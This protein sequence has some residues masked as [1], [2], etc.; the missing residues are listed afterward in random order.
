MA[1]NNVLDEITR[2][3]FMQEGKQQDF[4]RY[5]EKLS[6]HID[7][8]AQVSHLPRQQIEAIAY[9]T[10]RAYRL[11]WRT[12]WFWLA[13][14]VLLTISVGGIIGWLKYKS[15]QTAQPQMPGYIGQS[16]P[17]V[18]VQRAALANVLA[19]VV[20]LKTAIASYY[21]E[22]G[23]QPEN[24]SQLGLQAGEMTDGNYIKHVKIL[25]DGALRIE[26]S[27]F[28]G[29]GHYLVLTQQSVMG[30]S[31]IKWQCVSNLP[32]ETLALDYGQ[33]LCTRLTP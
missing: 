24:F 7:A 12:R 22:I 10:I 3:V 14:A 25:P 2:R 29:S 28:F 23:K 17:Q 4:R 33:N 21:V 20:P 8:L 11:T 26:L 9:E 6:D 1:D 27:E 18:Y 31:Q 19:L 32:E 16:S 5:S 30:G 15:A 13:G